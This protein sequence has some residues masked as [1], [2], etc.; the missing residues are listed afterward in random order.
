[1]QML[2][3]VLNTQ[4]CNEREQSR[5][6]SHIASGL[7]SEYLALFK[8]TLLNWMNFDPNEEHLIE[9]SADFNWCLS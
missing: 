4:R 9:L 6:I 8:T 3:F 1:M 2:N 5:D 7:V